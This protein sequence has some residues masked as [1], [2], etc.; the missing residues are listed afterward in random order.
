MTTYDDDLTAFMNVRRRLF[1]IACR[2][3]S[4]AAEAEDLVQDVWVRWQTTDRRQVR[5]AT[6]FLVTTT[7]RLAI[8]VMQ[9]AR[10]RHETPVGPDLPE[11]VDTTADPRLGAERSQ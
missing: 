5:D 9:S 2:M 4:N 6:A 10:S 8:N 1:G 11:P 7:R 3:L